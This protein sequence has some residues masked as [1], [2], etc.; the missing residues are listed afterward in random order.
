[1][2]PTEL[3]APEDRIDLLDELAHIYTRVRLASYEADVLVIG[4]AVLG[5][6]VYLPSK[7]AGARG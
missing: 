7:L 3:Q 1:M 4:A 2:T 6:T 5:V